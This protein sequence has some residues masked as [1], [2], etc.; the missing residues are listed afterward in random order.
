MKAVFYLA[1]APLLAALSA[2]AAQPQLLP[3]PGTAGVNP[4]THLVLRFASAPT[5]G[6]TGQVRI[7]D[8][9]DG[10]LVDTLDL[11]IP[12]GP[13]TR[14][15]APY[16]PYLSAPYPYGG[17][18]RTNADTRPGT[19]SVAGTQP[20]TANYQR[21]I[22]GGFTDGFHFHPVIVHGQVA[23]IYPHNDLL[24][25]GKT[26]YVE[27]DPGVLSTADGG[28]HGIQRKD[29]WRFSTRAQGPAPDAARVT[30]SADGQGDFATVQG[31]LDFV[32]DT[33]PGRV[34]IFV[35][36][37][38]YEEIV[39]ARNKHD[40]DIVGESRDGVRVHYPNNESFNPHPPGVGTNELP[41]TFPSRR[42]AFALDQ[43][44]GIHLVNL[45]VASDLEGQAE[46]LLLT[47]ERNI[48]S[49]VNIRGSG[50]ALQ[51]N[52][53]NYFSDV[54]LVG[55]GDA[56]LGRG[57]N[58]FQHCDIAAR[59]PFMWVRNPQGSHGNVFVDCSFHSRE[60]SPAGMNVLARLPDNKGKNY[61]YA[62]AVLIDATLDGI[63][64]EAWG[65]LDGDNS[66]LRF[67]EFNS[68]GVDG[69]P[70]DASRR[71][72]ASRQ[73]DAVR[74]AGLIAQYRDPAFVLKGWQPL[75]APIVLAQPHA[76]ADQAGGAT[77]LA[78][79]VAAVPAPAY[80]WLRDGVPVAGATASRLVTR[81]PGH[82]AVKV[83]NSAGVVTSEAA[84]LDQH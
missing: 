21:T 20:D 12:A 22:I 48:V 39:Y 5:L 80:Q 34:T 9:Q 26:Y 70:I 28:F 46:G 63:A 15:T 2:S 44:N 41:G 17:P 62:E 67:W 35:K 23:T 72:P 3:A 59:G 38:D 54:Q 65:Q 30:V 73:L 14:N 69:K 42:A 64:P 33:H 19:P 13:T 36:N 66:H 56:I 68:R 25:Y 50:D 78:V 16:P 10:R 1:A 81:V 45:S 55:G 24:A 58:F 76:S 83:S 47:G 61:P 75:M 32:P 79:E 53:R 11:A 82:Y 8:A 49:H 77:T 57:A 60:G 7:Y 37:G 51:A 74:D 71:H 29:G 31:A 18:R 40:I 84:T 27:I 4:D 6:N 43:A 52:G